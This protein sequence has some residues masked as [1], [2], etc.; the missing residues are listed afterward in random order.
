M[1][2]LLIVLFVVT[3]SLPFLTGKLVDMTFHEDHGYRQSDINGMKALQHRMLD[4]KPGRKMMT[5]AEQR[6]ALNDLWG[7]TK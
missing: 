7:D 6:Q 4:A 3:L 1:R 5:G 2:Y